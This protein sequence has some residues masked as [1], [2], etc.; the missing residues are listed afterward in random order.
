MNSIIRV[1]GELQVYPSGSQMFFRS[2]FRFYIKRFIKVSLRN[3]FALLGYDVAFSSTSEL[4]ISKRLQETT[5]RLSVADT[6]KVLDTI[7]NSEFRSFCL[8]HTEYFESGIQVLRSLFLLNGIGAGYF[9][10][11]G[12]CDGLLHSNTLL[13]EKKFGW[14]GLLVEP[15]RS[16]ARDIIANRSVSLDFRVVTSHSGDYQ[17]FTEVS[18]G[19]LSGISD[20]FREESKRQQLGIRTYKVETVSLNDLLQQWGAPIDFDFLSIDT[21]G[22][23]IEILRNFD[24]TKYSPKVVVVEHGGDVRAQLELENLME[25]YG[26]TSVANELGDTHNSWFV[27]SKSI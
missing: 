14:S 9:V 3:F 8:N 10:E 12:A 1:K 21:E 11:F 20:Y 19:G 24:L 13:L 5:S 6:L 22:S 4:I 7:S 2:L 25:A 27:R 23:E 16:F 18:S 17:D 26:Y 15:N